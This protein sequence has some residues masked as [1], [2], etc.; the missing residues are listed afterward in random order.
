MLDQLLSDI[1]E[2]L[3]TPPSDLVE[4]MKSLLTAYQESGNTEWQKYKFSNPHSYSRNLVHISPLF[5]AILLVW[6][7]GQ[8]SPIHNHNRSNCFFVVLEGSISETKY[9]YEMV[10]NKAS[11]TEIEQ[12]SYTAGDVAV[13]SEGDE[14]LHK[15]AGA[16]QGLSCTLHIYNRPIYKCSIFCPNTGNV[17]CRRP[18]FYTIYGKQLDSDITIYKKVYDELEAAD[19]ARSECNEPCPLALQHSIS[20]LKSSL[21]MKKKHADKKPTF[22]DMVDHEEEFS[23]TNL[24]GYT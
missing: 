22:L 8:I 4:A 10:G 15:V 12:G 21:E 7:K 6:D 3:T 2:T 18:G 24:E 5:E 23:N 14:I 9:S 16:G 17:E 20:E 19:A 11:L 1:S 13:V